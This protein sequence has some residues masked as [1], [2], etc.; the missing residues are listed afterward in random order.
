MSKVSGIA[1]GVEFREQVEE[2][3][4]AQGIANAIGIVGVALKG[5]LDAVFLSSQQE[6]ID[7]FGKPHENNSAIKGA[8]AC[9]QFSREVYFKR[10]VSVNARQGKSWTNETAKTSD[11]IGTVSTGKTY[12]GTTT[13]FPLVKGTVKVGVGSDIILHDDGKGNLKDSKGNQ[14]TIDYDEGDISLTLKEAVTDSTDV[15]ADYSFIDNTA[16]KPWAVFTTKE[17]SEMYNGWQVILEWENQGTESAPEWKVRY[18][19]LDSTG[20]VQERYICSAVPE[21]EV[22]FAKIINRYSAYITADIDTTNQPTSADATTLKFTLVN[23]NSGLDVTVDDI[24]GEGNTG[25]QAFYDPEVLDIATLVV[26]TWADKKVWLEGKRICDYRRD[27]VFIPSLPVGL[28]PEQVIDLVR[29]AG[30]FFISGMQFDHTCMPLYWPNGIIKKPETGGVDIVDIAPYVAATYAYSD[31]LEQIWFAPGGVSRGRVFGLDGLEYRASKEERDKLYSTEVNVNSV[32]DVRGYG[33]CLMG[34][35]TSKVYPITAG[36]TALRYINI[37]RMCNY[38]R[39]VLLQVSLNNLFDQNDY[40]TWNDWK[41]HVDPYLR[42]IKENRGLTD[43]KVVMDESTV[44]RQDIDAGRMPG[45]I[46]IAPV[47]PNEYII[48][49]FV[50][51]KDGTVTFEDEVMEVA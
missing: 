1:P 33:L 44:S 47:K 40:Y 24:I 12:T 23:G 37:R 5:P 20:E 2:A 13:K 19:L 26:P 30:E 21:D 49:N 3:S 27:I 35:R 15:V 36:N 46:R 42:A 16:T 22:Y 6:C 17:L 28:V 38:I 45:Q 4:K 7:T 34:V 32:V 18:Q 43:Y 51:A 9:L 29:G 25:M 48:I 50:I 41:L 31:S 8:L 10:V 14:G 11:A 39:K